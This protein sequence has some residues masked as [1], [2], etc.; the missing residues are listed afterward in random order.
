MLVPARRLFNLAV[1]AIRRNV[2]FATNDP[3]SKLNF[4]SWI[5]LIVD[6]VQN[7]AFTP[8]EVATLKGIQGNQDLL[9]PALNRAIAKARGAILAGGF[10]LGADGT[11]PDQV[12]DS[13]IDIAAWRW[14]KSFPT[15]KALQTKD[16]KDAFD[17]AVER[18]KG[19]TKKEEAIEAPDVAEASYPQAAVESSANRRQAS[20]CRLDGI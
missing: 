7:E 3:Q 6:D 14:L 18:L 10:V 20:R 4:M 2:R 19:I 11:V 17:A 5:I 16:R 15:L 1:E 9:T 12:S 13:V 8:Q